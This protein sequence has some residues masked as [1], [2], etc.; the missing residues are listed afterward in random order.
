MIFLVLLL[1]TQTTHAGGSNVLIK[2]IEGS[3]S[4]EDLQAKLVKHFSTNDFQKLLTQLS[5]PISKMDIP[6][7]LA[8]SVDFVFD[9][10]E[11]MKSS[12]IEECWIRPEFASRLVD[13]WL[14]RPSASVPGS[15]ALDAY[16]AITST[17]KWRSQVARSHRE[18][19]FLIRWELSQSPIPSNK[20][21]ERQLEELEEEFDIWWNN[22]KKRL[23]YCN[24]ICRFRFGSSDEIADL[25]KSIPKPGREHPLSSFFFDDDTAIFITL[26]TPPSSWIEFDP[27]EFLRIKRRNKKG[28]DDNLITLWAHVA[29]SSRA[30]DIVL[31][32][33]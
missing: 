28:M 9:K 15:S 4:K 30:G 7:F 13:A 12:I 16:G 20:L 19:A 31:S 3:V 1:A 21:R 14:C 27:K 5:G 2:A 26:S 18:L 11:E 24:R 33:R 25:K 32:A 23:V 6:I 22:N 17:R 8:G 29:S 10:K